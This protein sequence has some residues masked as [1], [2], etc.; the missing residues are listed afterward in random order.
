MKLANRL[1][2]IAPF[3]VMDLLAKAKQMQ[4]AGRDVIHLEVGE[5]DF[6]T[7]QP[8]VDAGIA[9]LN[10]GQTHYTAAT[11]LPELK[12]AIC[13]FYDDRYGKS[14]SPDQIVITPGASGALQL[15]TALLANQNENI[16]LA[17]PGYPCNRHFMRLIN[18]DGKLVA[19]NADEHFQLTPNHVAEH[20]DQRT[21]GA[22]VASP[23]NP[24]GAAMSAAEIEALH[25]SVKDKQGILVVDEIYHGLTYDSDAP[26]ATAVDYVNGGDTFVIN[27][28]SKYFGMTGWRLGWIVAPKWAVPHLDKLAQNIFL[29]APTPAQHAALAAFKSETLSIL[30]QR[31]KEFANRL[32]YLLPELKAL[33]FKVPVEPKGAFYIYCDVSDFTQDSMQFCLDLLEQEA[34]AITPGIDFGEQ[35]GQ[36]FVR[37]AYTTEIP[38]LKEA[39]SRIQRFLMNL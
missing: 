4:V 2:H 13:Q 30:E 25:R 1:Q 19:T 14:V 23:T 5:P 26:A 20:W 6:T 31:R 11:G 10:A 35:D 17:D 24:T 39:V 9:A 36:H 37:F 21:I 34:V 27:S 8:I 3:H 28:F 29:A 38:R 18:A 33:G 16:L 7:P 12:Q 15:V 32:A 22:L